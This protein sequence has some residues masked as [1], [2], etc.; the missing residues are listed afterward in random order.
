M[1]QKIEYFTN[2]VFYH[3]FRFD[4]LGQRIFG[5]PIRCFI[6]LP[7]I[8]KTFKQGVEN[9]EKEI[10]EALYNPKNGFNI[11]H[12]S[13][14]LTGLFWLIFF[15][16]SVFLIPF[17]WSD[18]EPFKEVNIHFWLFMLVTFAPAWIASEMLAEHK[19][20]YLKYFKQFEKKS[21]QWHSRTAWLT[22]FTVV[23]IWGYAIGGFAF[24]LS[25]L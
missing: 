12:A 22:F 23:G 4:K 13:W 7:I 20:K 21:E 2:L 15:G 9:A 6:R 14:H 25:R 19:K 3:L 16:T 5:A 18:F 8:A 10:N 24:Y 17:L 1:R 11:I